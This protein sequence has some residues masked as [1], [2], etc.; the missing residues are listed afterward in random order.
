[1]LFRSLS[2]LASGRRSAFDEALSA[3]FS[4]L[5]LSFR[6]FFFS[7]GD[8]LPPSSCFTNFSKLKA[9]LSS[10]MSS[11]EADRL[12]FLLGFADWTDGWTEEGAFQSGTSK[13]GMVTE[14][15]R[16]VKRNWHK[17]NRFLDGSDYVLRLNTS[18]QRL[19]N[20]VYSERPG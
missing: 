17:Q 13:S 2:F 10:R 16:R 7:F 20:R 11:S 1:M 9:A 5:R 19:K 8:V 6:A 18:F 3:F 4:D 14:T 15:G 12:R